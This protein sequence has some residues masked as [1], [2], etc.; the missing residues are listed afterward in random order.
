[1]LVCLTAFYQAEVG[2]ADAPPLLPGILSIA[3]ALGFILAGLLLHIRAFLFVGTAVFMI[4]VLRQVARFAS[5]SLPLWSMGIVLGIAF[6]WI[7]ATF[8]ARRT[9]IS[10]LMNYW[11]TEL[12]AWE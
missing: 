10:T 5:E 7:A 8:E 11:S 6:I 12:E 4:Q 3:I 9:Q 1:A 2:I